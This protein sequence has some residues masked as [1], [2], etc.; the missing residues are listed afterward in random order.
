MVFWPAAERIRVSAGWLRTWSGRWSGDDDDDEGADV[1][2]DNES[3]DE[4]LLTRRR[5]LH[6]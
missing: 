5:I 1:G 2:N 3:I 4:G 6:H